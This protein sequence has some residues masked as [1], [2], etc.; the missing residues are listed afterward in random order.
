M[1]RHVFPTAPS[2]TTTHLMVCMSHA[3]AWTPKTV[4]V[5]N[6]TSELDEK[7]AQAACANAELVMNSPPQMPSY[8]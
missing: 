1:S 8:E 6:L 3:N 7:R 5:Y 4:A 2:P